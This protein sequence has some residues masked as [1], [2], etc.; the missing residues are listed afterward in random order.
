[1]NPWDLDAWMR[2][3][4]ALADMKRY[5]E[6]LS[7]YGNFTRIYPD[8]WEVWFNKGTILSEMG[9]HADAI[10]SYDR[11]LT[12][13]KRFPEVWRMKGRALQ[14]LDRDGEASECLREAEIL[15]AL[16]ADKRA[17]QCTE[18]FSIETTMYVNEPL[19]PLGPHSSGFY[20]VTGFGEIADLL[21]FLHRY[22]ELDK[23][24]EPR[25]IERDG[26]TCLAAYESGFFMPIY[27]NESFNC[28]ET[29]ALVEYYLER[30]GINAS[31]ACAYNF[32]A[33]G[34]AWVKV[35]LPGGP[36]YIDATNFTR[37]EDGVLELIAPGDIG[38]A[39]YS[40][41]DR[42]YES[43]YDVLLENHVDIEAKVENPLY[44]EFDWWE[45]EMFEKQAPT[46][47][48]STTL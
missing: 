4:D 25:L 21:D 15:E 27:T 18:G 47:W 45:S 41:Y 30:S 24:L 38:Y 46:S 42:L 3:G 10:E 22:Y 13:D 23:P 35:D 8:F 7:C 33:V 40:G 20:N 26:N 17:Y 9:R 48:L 39:R 36:Y 34:H 29:A 6:A 43:I 14:A 2:K 12:L 31:I 44:Y 11:A 32:S 16:S 5:P 19:R 1:M 37:P 28:G